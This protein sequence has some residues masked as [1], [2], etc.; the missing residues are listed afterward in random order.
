MGNRR[1][2][3]EP[4]FNHQSFVRLIIYHRLAETGKV[5]GAGVE[6]QFLTGIGGKHATRDAALQFSL[7]V[8]GAGVEGENGILAIADGIDGARFAGGRDARLAL[9]TEG[10]PPKSTVVGFTDAAARVT[11]WSA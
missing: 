6:Q 1:T 7:Q 4:V 2:L 9:L 8:V 5:I 11:A 3:G 10:P